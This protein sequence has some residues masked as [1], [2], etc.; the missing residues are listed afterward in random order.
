LIKS[1][2]NAANV[3]IVAFD[4][5]NR[6]S[7]DD[8]RTYWRELSGFDNNNHNKYSPWALGCLVGCKSDLTKE[9]TVLDGEAKAFAD[10]FGWIYETCSAKEDTGV[11]SLFLSVA[12]QSEKVFREWEENAPP[13]KKDNNDDSS[14]YEEILLGGGSKKHCCYCFSSRRIIYL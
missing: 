12:L 6:E 1:Y 13:L 3:I 7:F 8:V 9:R 5:T 11:T 4:L 10:E 2:F 14:N